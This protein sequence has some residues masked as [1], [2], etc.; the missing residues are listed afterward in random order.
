MIPKGTT[1]APSEFWPSYSF[2]LLQYIKVVEFFISATL[3]LVVSR[4]TVSLCSLKH[5]LSHLSC[6]FFFFCTFPS[7]DSYLITCQNPLPFFITFYICVNSLLFL[8]RRENCQVSFDNTLHTVS[9]DKQP[10]IRQE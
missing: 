10:Q 9:Y 3:A 7:Y 5:S 1:V 6:V 2:L 8:Y 4:T